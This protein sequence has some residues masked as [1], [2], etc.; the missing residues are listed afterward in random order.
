M[1]LF[2]DHNK[3]HAGPA[4]FAENSRYHRDHI[5]IAL[6]NNMP[7]AAIEDTEAQFTGLLSDAAGDLPVQLGFY[8]L[9]TVP[10]SG[11]AK[12]KLESQYLA[13][14]HLRDEPA[15]ALIITGTEPH[16]EDLRDEP[17]WRELSALFEWAEA[18]THSSVLSCLAAH[19]A[20]LHGDG[21]VRRTREEKQFGIFEETLV[22]EHP[23]TKGIQAPL[24]IPHSRCNGL[25]E[26]DLA[27]CRYQVLTRS[28]EAGAGMFVKMRGQSLFVHFQGHPEYG[29][30]VLLK[31]YRRDVGRYLRGERSKYPL[32]PGG[33]FDPASEKRLAEFQ[34]HAASTPSS[35]ALARFP[36]AEVADALTPSW[37]PAAVR[38]YSNW[39]KHLTMC[40]AAKT[41]P[42]ASLPDR[43][44]SAARGRSEPLSAKNSAAAARR[45]AASRAHD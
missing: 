13:W 27:N 25:G 10:R 11:R 6:V 16:T 21:I 31:E 45:R 14:H 19:A 17:Y 8:F 15:D 34:R 32:L 22:C 12:A 43:S 2:V 44:A 4:K 37:R 38:I 9:P 1:P 23:L 20:V 7:D 33:Y 3:V 39:L 28:A 42:I 18:N 40:K 5:R 35:D 30:Q 36:E 29:P 24:R 26:G 41:A